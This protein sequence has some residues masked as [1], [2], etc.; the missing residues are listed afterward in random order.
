M[1]DGEVSI[2]SSKYVSPLWLNNDKRRTIRNE[3][4]VK[5]TPWISYESTNGR[6]K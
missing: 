4:A 1:L 5:K 2:S 3:I 6:T